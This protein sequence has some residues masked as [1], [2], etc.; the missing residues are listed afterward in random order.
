VYAEKIKGMQIPG[1]RPDAY[2]EDFCNIVVK[3]NGIG[4]EQHYADQ[5]FQSFK[6]L[7]SYERYEGSGLGLS[8]CRKIIEKHKGV[9]TANGRVD[10]GATF[11]ISVPLKK[12]IGVE[13]KV[14]QS[15]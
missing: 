8:I 2:D 9:I 5:I 13:L 11:T 3:D 7:H 10:E 4:F 6:R 14:K 12:E 1:I 15:A